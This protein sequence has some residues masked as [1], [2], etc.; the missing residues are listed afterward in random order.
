MRDADI[1]DD[2]RRAAS[3]AAPGHRLSGADAFEDGVGTD[4]L[5]HVF[6][7]GDA[8]IAAFGHDIGGAELARQASDAARAGS[9]R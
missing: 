3:T 7:A 8:V 5:G 1:A 9:S 4:A 2:T 6:D